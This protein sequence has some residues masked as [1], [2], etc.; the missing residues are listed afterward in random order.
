MNTKKT[1]LG[2]ALAAIAS[3]AATAPVIPAMA[4]NQITGGTRE[5]L[6]EYGGEYTDNQYY[7]VT[8][9]A[10]MRPGGT[11]TVTLEGVWSPTT[12]IKVIAPN[13][14][15]LTNNIDASS[16]KELAITF[17]DITKAGDVNKPISVKEDISL[18]NITNALIGTWSGTITYNVTIS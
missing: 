17:N 7:E 4:T 18:A 6:V 10:S 3:V 2:L 9:P 11:G 14:V 5:T 1:C 12:T 15:K 8:V 13:A 16:V